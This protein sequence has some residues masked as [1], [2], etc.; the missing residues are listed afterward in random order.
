MFFREALSTG[1]S[2]DGSIEVVGK[3]GDPFEARDRIIEL[4]PDVMTLD[5]E[6]PKMSGLDFLKKLMPQYPIPTVVVSGESSNV[7]DAMN[8]GAVDFV[9]KPRVKT[10]EDLDRFMEELATKVKIA[11][12]A[13]V[14]DRVTDSTAKQRPISR[15]AGTASGRMAVRDKRI[16]AIGASTGGTE[17]INSILR[18]FPGNMPGVVIVQHMPPVFT[19][20]YAERLD[21][22]CSMKVKEAEDGDIVE[23][24]K[25]LLAPGGFHMRIVRSG[26]KYRV[27]VFEGD[28]VSGHCPSV[29]V[30]FSSMA[31]SVG[32]RGIGIILTG[33]GTDGAKGMLEMKK[34]GA[35]TIGQDEKSSVVYG[36]PKMAYNIGAVT[37]QRPLS[38]IPESVFD[39][40]RL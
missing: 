8:S 29:D 11:S 3:A 22:N 32:K 30:L 12:T 18:E 31:E 37:R 14:S 39:F 2:R 28:K 26:T 25:V 13:K 10:P 21:R 23:P 40:L 24:G 7:F 27:K 20:M 36:M 9:S 6:M 17:A 35:R 1:L 34:N 16:I 38:E 19:K 4:R 33:M 15:V 5:V